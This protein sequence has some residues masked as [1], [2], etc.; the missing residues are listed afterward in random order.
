MTREQE[1][2]Q[3]ALKYLDN[4]IPDVYG[5]CE[6]DIY[7]AF[8]AGAEWENKNPKLPWIN[9]EDK[10]PTDCE[11]VFIC[12][13]SPIYG[14]NFYDVGNLI[15]DKWLNTKG[16]TIPEVLYWMPIPGLSKE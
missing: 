11:D 5:I 14:I 4:F 6:Q 2:K 9:V 7:E 16:Y 13:K 12:Y 3:S 1:I 15:G 10:L 8:I